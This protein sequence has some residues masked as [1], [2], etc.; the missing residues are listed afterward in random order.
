MKKTAKKTT[1]LIAPVKSLADMF[2]RAATEPEYRT[3]AIIAAQNLGGC[4][5]P[6]IQSTYEAAKRWLLL[7]AQETTERGVV[8]EVN[9][10]RNLVT[11]GR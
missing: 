11:K 6:D 2:H 5:G 4:G 8:E 3:L 9:F 10:C 7:T 1:G